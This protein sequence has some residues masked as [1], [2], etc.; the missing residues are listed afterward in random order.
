[1]NQD[2]TPPVPDITDAVLRALRGMTQDHT[3]PV[4][5][6]APDAS[7]SE[8]T[9]PKV[10]KQ[11]RSL[12]DAMLG[13]NGWPGLHT[14]EQ[15]A[16]H[17]ADQIIQGLVERWH[18]E[19]NLIRQK[20]ADSLTD[21]VLDSVPKTS[22]KLATHAKQIRDAIQQNEAELTSP[23][24]RSALIAILTA[25]LLGQQNSFD[26]LK[27]L[28]LQDLSERTISLLRTVAETAPSSSEAIP[29]ACPI[30]V[31][32]ILEALDRGYLND[33]DLER[34]A[35]FEAGL[36]SDAV[37]HQPT[38]TI[39]PNSETVGQ[40]AAPIPPQQSTEAAAD[41]SGES[42]HGV[43]IFTPE[44]DG[45]RIVGFGEG[46]H[47]SAK[48]CKGLDQIFTLIQ[49]PGVPVSMQTL[50]GA[51]KDERLKADKHSPQDSADS[52]MLKQVAAKLREARDEL[53]AAEKSNDTVDANHCRE[54]FEKWQA[55]WNK[56]TGKGGEARDINNPFDKWR[57]R[58]HGTL[59]TAY[60]KLRDARMTEL[61][62]HFEA[63]IGSEGGVN[64][65]YRSTIK[66]SPKWQTDRKMSDGI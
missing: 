2:D 31:E 19:P 20:I 48:G 26:S 39:P 61:A 65:V 41:D 23:Q 12:G 58:I 6:F 46:G 3:P 59:A 13:P 56:L 1:M 37:L 40:V 25:R 32:E 50:V 7:D 8:G 49:S 5:L 66:P 62:T 29:A 43:W 24:F 52:P 17:G 11:N 15:I 14:T 36:N 34:S 44:T 51:D 4:P 47:L 60:E 18:D 57:K 9:S 33:R 22:R 55:E 16:E 28:L 30:D 63:A 38:N 53:Q 54:E 27:R 10:G 45:Y 21:A 64:Y 35:A 42:E